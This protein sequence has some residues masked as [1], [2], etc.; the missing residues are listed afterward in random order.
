MPSEDHHRGLIITLVIAVAVAVVGIG[1][2]ALATNDTDGSIQ[3]ELSASA[4]NGFALRDQRPEP[5]DSSQ[6][7]TVALS[8]TRSGGDRTVDIQP[9]YDAFNNCVGEDASR[10]G[11]IK[12]HKGTQTIT[13]TVTVKSG[14]TC[15]FEESKMHWVLRE[16]D[17]PQERFLFVELHKPA[18]KD[19]RYEC[20]PAAPYWT[21]DEHFVTDALYVTTR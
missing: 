19:S 8:G 20:G 14:G 16:Q 12:M 1:V 7:I 5:N 13:L 2:M 10:P 11:K 17:A 15:N 9:V 18:G 3:D 4:Q 21:C 6:S